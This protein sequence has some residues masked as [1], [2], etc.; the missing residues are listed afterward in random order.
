MV[1]E[2]G[3]VS[4]NLIPADAE[5]DP[6]PHMPEAGHA[7]KKHGAVKMPVSLLILSVLMLCSL[8]VCTWFF[9]YSAEN[10]PDIENHPQ[11]PGKLY[12]PTEE[13]EP[14]IIN[15]EPEPE[16]EEVEDIVEKPPAVIAKGVYLAAWYP[17]RIPQYIELGN[18]T[19]FNALVLDIKDDYGHITFRTET[20][21]LSAS[22]RSYFPNIGE[23]VAQLKSEG[24]YTIARIVCFRDPYWGAVRPDL[25]LQDSSGQTWEDSSGK[26]WLNPYNK[27]AWAIIADA[28]LEAARVGFEEVQL[29]YVR[30][31]S[32]GRLSDIDYGDAMDEKSRTEIIAEFVAYIR[33]ILA[34]EGVRLSIDVFG[35]IALSRNDASIIGQDLS[36]L[37]PNADYISPM[38]YP[39]HFANKNQNGVGQII[40]GVLFEAPDLDPYGVVYNILMEYRRQLPDD[41]GDYAIIRP[42]LQDFTAA[43]LG[44]GFFQPYDAT[45]V[46]EQVQAVYDAG[47]EEWL[48]WNHGSTYSVDAFIGDTDDSEDIAQ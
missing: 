16:P 19:E 39:S 13:P 33:E 38:I 23:T 17:D 4:E 28:A 42:Y 47:F 7:G 26:K 1:T 3:A 36:L 34:K 46:R 14:A 30:F 2:N 10:S 6:L 27:D 40:N 31:P 35:I 9:V 12:D 20:E 43:Y 25:A 22:S 41:G 29:D 37:L 48:L 44:E 8:A 11:E 45:Q 32:G 15:P 21:S 24:I 5:G 18:T